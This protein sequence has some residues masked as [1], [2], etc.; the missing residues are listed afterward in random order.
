MLSLAAPE[1][2]RRQGKIPRYG[3]DQ[4]ILVPAALCLCECPSSSL[5][6][7]S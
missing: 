3:G 5:H 4:E 7:L 6:R 1:D 2:N